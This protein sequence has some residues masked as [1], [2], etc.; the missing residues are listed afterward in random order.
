MKLKICDK[1][2]KKTMNF[3]HQKTIENLKFLFLRKQNQKLNT[4]IKIDLHLFQ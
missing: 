3:V 2:G 4:K 1:I